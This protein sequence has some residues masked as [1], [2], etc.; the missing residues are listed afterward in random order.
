MKLSLNGLV[1]YLTGKGM[2][3][4]VNADAKDEDEVFDI[5]DEEEDEEDDEEEK[6]PVMKN[7]KPKANAAEEGAED[8]TMLSETELLALKSFA[9][10][11]ATNQ[12]LTAAL[13][14]GS[15]DAALKTVPA[16][17]ELVRN[18]QAQAKAEKDTL[19]TTIKANGSNDLSDEELGAMP[20]TALVKLN[21]RMNV[22]YAGLGGANF[23]QNAEQP[24][25][26]RPM[27]L[28]KQQKETE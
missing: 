4:A 8:P 14:D 5:E 12:S 24:L 23:I 10:K 18:A 16:A 17:A 11:L 1:G 25:T 27:L 26:I 6:E 28:M 2:K 22:S 7:K 19:I 20:V 13:A 21:A 9:Q 15:L 3:I